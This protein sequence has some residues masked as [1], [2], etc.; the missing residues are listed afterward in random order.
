MVDRFKIWISVDRITVN[1]I[2][3]HCERITGLGEKIRLYN[4][5]LRI[6][7]ICVQ[8]DN[9]VWIIII[10]VD[11][12]DFEKLIFGLQTTIL[13][14]LKKWLILIKTLF[15]WNLQLKMNNGQ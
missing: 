10:G 4:Y 14:M 2:T 8:L 5:I 11:S 15:L 13:I 1:G 9:C 12:D 3:S 6:L 7:S